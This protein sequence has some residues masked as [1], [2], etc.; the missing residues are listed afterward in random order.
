M[1]VTI[2]VVH[3]TLDR[4]ERCH[5]INME[6]ASR[7]IDDAVSAGAQIVCFPETYPGPWKEGTGLYYQ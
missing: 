6:R 3:T 7:Y 1:K 5:E 2:A 4:S